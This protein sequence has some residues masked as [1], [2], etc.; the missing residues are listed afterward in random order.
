MKERNE[1]ELTQDELRHCDEMLQDDWEREYR[2]AG[3]FQTALMRTIEC[4]DAINL[5]KLGTVY[6]NIVRAYQKRI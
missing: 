3:S 6:P 5:K 2:Y 1:M 4:A